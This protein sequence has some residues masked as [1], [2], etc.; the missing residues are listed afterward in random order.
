MARFL[1]GGPGALPQKLYAGRV[2]HGV[3]ALAGYRR[4]IG[5]MRL[6]R[7]SGS[8]SVPLWYSAFPISHSGVVD[9]VSL[10]TTFQ[11]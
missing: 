11:P 8:S 5:T 9:N 2:R 10:T 4:A 6:R 3:R 7:D 1:A